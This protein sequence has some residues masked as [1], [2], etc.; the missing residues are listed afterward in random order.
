[1]IKQSTICFGL[2]IITFCVSCIGIKNI[3]EFSSP[4]DYQ[5][6]YQY[7]VNLHAHTKE[8]SGQY[9][10]SPEEL[11]I[12]AK[13]YG[14]DAYAIT[15]LPDAG[16]L[17]KPP[18][19]PGILHIPGIEYGGKP[20]LVG[21]GI[22]SITKSI[23]KQEQINHIKRQN[24]IAIIPHP[25]FGQYDENLLD[26]LE[27]I[28]GVVV[29][30]SLT[31]SVALFN[32]EANKVLPYNE[33]LIDG[34]LTKKKPIAIMS[35]E[36]TKYENPHKYGHQLNTAWLK[37]W[38]NTPLNELKVDHLIEAI[39]KRRFTS[40]AR[41]KRD[42]PAPP[43]FSKILTDGLSVIVYLNKPCR[44]QFITSGGKVGKEII[45]G[46]IGV[47]KASPDD[48]YV[49]IKAICGTDEISWAWSN[50]M[51]ITKKIH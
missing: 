37:V 36:D 23:N 18:D 13:E 30:N 41:Q 45:N 3:Y 4:Y 10:Y 40:H 17:V 12:K 9:A 33:N 29:F 48:L 6:V 24:G 39:N 15:D 46:T 8:R 31:Y 7:K 14:F 11:L 49:R 1:M 35:E 34:I 16:G 50:P 20:H 27:G 51:F 47:Y 26:S 19:V 38:S 32:G 28:D 42:H 44:I 5:Y 22:D 21:I 25:Y 43:E 2:I